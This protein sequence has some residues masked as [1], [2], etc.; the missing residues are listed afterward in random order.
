MFIV[1]KPPPSSITPLMLVIDEVQAL[2][3]LAQNESL[4]YRLSTAI[5]STLHKKSITGGVAI[6]RPPPYTTNRCKRQNNSSAVVL[7]SSKCL[8]ARLRRTAKL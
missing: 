2:H 1:Q 7:R 3:D 8:S 6:A 4:F 5:E